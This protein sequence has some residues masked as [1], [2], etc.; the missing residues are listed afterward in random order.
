[1]KGILQGSSER[2]FAAR[3]VEAQFNNVGDVYVSLEPVRSGILTIMTG[4][5]IFGPLAAIFIALWII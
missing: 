5:F 4:N 2:D 1:M 3:L